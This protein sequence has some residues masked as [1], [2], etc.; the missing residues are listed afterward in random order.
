MWA[1]TIQNAVVLARATEVAS[2]RGSGPM[3][4]RTGRDTLL[5]AQWVYSSF[6]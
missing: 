3:A 4:N 5:D 6:C 2:T 1:L